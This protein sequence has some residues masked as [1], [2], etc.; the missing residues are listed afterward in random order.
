MIETWKPIPG[1]E[2]IYSASNTGLIKS[3]TSRQQWKSGRILKNLVHKGGYLKLRLWKNSRYKHFLVHRLIALTFL[4]P[5]PPKHEVNHKDGNKANNFINNLEYVTPKENT[6]HAV[7]SG[8]FNDRKGEKSVRSKLT[9]KQVIEIRKK[10]IPYKYS[11][12]KIAK[13]F[14]VCPSTIGSIIRYTSW[15]HI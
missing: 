5:C 3:E 7:R 14:N 12:V 15:S 8:L 1:Y 10:H 11:T 4:G 2:G 6:N 13:E 9:N